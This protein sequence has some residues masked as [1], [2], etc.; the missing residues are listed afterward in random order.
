MIPTMTTSDP[1]IVQSGFWY[2][3]EEETVTL[4]NEDKA[5]PMIMSPI[6]IIEIG[7]FL[8]FRSNAVMRLLIVQFI[9]SN[10]LL[11]RDNYLGD[12]IIA[13]LDRF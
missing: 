13:G 11:R 1:Y 7:K 10:A 9:S 3:K 2:M 8:G 6:S 5:N 12:E 4:S